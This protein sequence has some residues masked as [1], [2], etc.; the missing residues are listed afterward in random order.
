MGFAN[1]TYFSSDDVKYRRSIKQ[2]G[3]R[4]NSRYQV[5]NGSTFSIDVQLFDNET[6]L[7]NSLKND[8]LQPEHCNRKYMGNIV[9]QIRSGL[10]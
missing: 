5:G 4:L 10:T 9:F 2:F 7:W 3:E 8:A 6:D 1:V